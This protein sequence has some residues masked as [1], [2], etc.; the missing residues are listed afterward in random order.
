MKKIIL[1]TLLMAAA[2]A[3]VWADDNGTILGNGIAA[4]PNASSTL[5]S[6]STLSTG[7]VAQPVPEIALQK[8]YQECMGG[9]TAQQNGLR[10]QYCHCVHDQLKKMNLDTYTQMATQAQKVQQSG[11]DPNDLPH[12]IQQIAHYC[13]QQ[14]K[15]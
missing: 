11:G 5:G 6:N 2:T 8:D 10:D 12:Q 3:P 15:F 9:A 13:M 1:T 7:I 14:V 4:Q